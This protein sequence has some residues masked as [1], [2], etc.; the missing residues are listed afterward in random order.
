M[1]EQKEIH[2]QEELCFSF[3]QL[4]CVCVCV[5]AVGVGSDE[6]PSHHLS[7]PGG[8]ECVSLER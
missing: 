2:K 8:W 6:A 4:S 1:K 3:G 7:P 5:H